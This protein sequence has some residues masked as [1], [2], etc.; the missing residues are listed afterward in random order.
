M[1]ASQGVCHQ[2]M[3]GVLIACQC[4][5]LSHNRVAHRVYSYQAEPPGKR[6]ILRHGDVCGWPRAREACTLLLAVGHEGLLH[7]TVNLVLC[8]IRSADKAMEARERQEQTHQANPTRAYLDTDQVD[9]QDQA[10]QERETWHALE[11]RHDRGTLV[12][13]LLIRTPCLQRAARHLKHLSGLTLGDPLGV[14]RAIP[15]TQRS[16]FEASPVLV[17]IFVASLRMLDYRSH[18]DLLVPSFAFVSVMAKD[19]EV[20]FWFQPFAG[21][22][23]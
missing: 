16:A 5:V 9:G 23:H 19:G 7:T 1:Q 12:Q 4:R 17:A 3:P 2:G 14:Q 21:S 18:S 15:L 8:P 6:F 10:M 20:A 22:S 11:K 13:A